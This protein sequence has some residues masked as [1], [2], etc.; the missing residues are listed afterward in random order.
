MA[1]CC[2]IF[3]FYFIFCLLKAA[4]AAYGGSQ[5]RGQIKAVAAGLHHSHSNAR[6]LTHRARPGIEPASFWIL[7]RFVSPEPQQE[8]PKLAFKYYCLEVLLCC[9]G[10]M[11]QCCRCYAQVWPLAQELA[12]ATDAAKNKKQNYCLARSWN[13]YLSFTPFHFPIIWF[14]QIS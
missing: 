5:A 3:L 11:F 8:L 4:P 6:S 2:F 14:D 13:F 9:W 10:I 12:C 7:V 1:S